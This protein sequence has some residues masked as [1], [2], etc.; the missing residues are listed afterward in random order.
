MQ[1]FVNV[2]PGGPWIVCGENVVVDETTGRNFDYELTGGHS[3]V[4]LEILRLVP[5]GEGLGRMRATTEILELL[6]RTLIERGIRDVF[7][8]IPLL[9]PVPKVK[10]PAYVQSVADRIEHARTRTPYAAKMMVDGFCLERIPGWEE[11]YVSAE[12]LPRFFDPVSMAQ[13]ALEENLPEKNAQLAIDGHNRVVF[14]VNDESSP[15]DTASVIEACR[16]IDFYSLPNI[17][18][19]YFEVVPRHIRS[20]FRRQSGT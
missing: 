3:K 10:R 9:P 19:V 15:V 5:D 11:P 4:A 13:R 16:R 6:R 8:R 1:R 14:I 17:D 18:E 12:K 20:V 2:M 7:V